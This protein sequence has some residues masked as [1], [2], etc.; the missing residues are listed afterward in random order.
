MSAQQLNEQAWNAFGRHHL[1]SGTVLL[2][3][4]RIDWALSAAGPGTEVLGPLEGRRVLDLGSGTGR[5]AAHL[6]R[7]HQALVHAVDSSAWQH[8][9]AVSAYGHL[10]GLH[11]HLADALDHLASAEPYDVIYAVNS[12][13][14]M[15]PH[16]ALAAI[17][18]A[19][20]PGGLLA[21]SVLHTPSDR[22]PP[23][24]TVTPRPETLR[25]R[26]GEDLTVHM[27]VLTSQLWEDLAVEAGLRVN[28]V[29]TI[30]SPDDSNPVSYRLFL[31]HRA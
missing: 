5:H 20:A 3:A 12:L 8:Q 28:E 26:G 7:D 1:D 21:F 29:I 14:F 19:L 11:F 27:Y 30:E 17:A 15:A 16:E 13:P 31:T 23:S 10:P 4:V 25:L 24:T 22:R 2:D 9:R 6:A 18:D